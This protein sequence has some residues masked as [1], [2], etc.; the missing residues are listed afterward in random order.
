[1]PLISLIGVAKSES[2][3]MLHG[4]VFILWAVASAVEP[5]DLPL[6]C[7]GEGSLKMLQLQSTKVSSGEEL[8]DA[9]NAT[10]DPWGFKATPAVMPSTTP[11]ELKFK[12]PYKFMATTT[13]YGD[14]SMSAC[15]SLDT[16]KLVK[17]TQYYN[18]ATAEN[19]FGKSW[20]G[21]KWM[22]CFQCAKGKFLRSHKGGFTGRE[23]K[24]I[25]GDLC[26]YKG[27][28]R[29]CPGRTTSV[30]GAH[31]TYHMDFSHPPPG[32]DNNLIA[33]TPIPCGSQIERRIAKFKAKCRR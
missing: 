12:G 28:E 13:R 26:P 8:E 18:V 25:V 4:M 20:C 31:F 15:G 3:D 33:F 23:I 11:Y 6:D 21:K 30:N 19:M 10:G 27:N 16:A 24:I 7:E 1:V 17:G 14:A 5:D 2:F 22:G 32:I 29:W 9:S